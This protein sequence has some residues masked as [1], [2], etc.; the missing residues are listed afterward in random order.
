MQLDSCSCNTGANC[1][2]AQVECIPS[3]LQP[4]RR[5]RQFPESDLL[6]RLRKYEEILRQK[7]VKVE[8]LTHPGP[9]SSATQSPAH[10]AHDASDSEGEYEKVVKS[11][12]AGLDK[13]SPGG[14]EISE[15]LGP[16][17]RR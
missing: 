3:T 17:N 8:P 14:T 9:S 7:G 10:D 4:R 15:G 6:E 11:S 13:P 5:R 2:K 16:G 1:I 12:S